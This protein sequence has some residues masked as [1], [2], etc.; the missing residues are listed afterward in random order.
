M[1]VGSSQI[2][3]PKYSLIC[4][5]FRTV[6]LGFGMTRVHHEITIIDIKE[7]LMKTLLSALCILA[8]A[9]AC[10]KEPAA[11]YQEKQQEVMKDYREDVNQATQ[12]R[13]EEIQEATEDRNEAMGD[14]TEDLRE[15]QK[16]EAE[17]YVED[18]E[19]ATVN[20]EMERVNVIE[21]EDQQ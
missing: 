9:V 1:N 4:C 16:E 14:A 17:D 8:L 7:D 2:S 10:N 21:E 13:N 15:E 19:S 18:S 6:I 20:E 12:D 3:N 11:E 5:S